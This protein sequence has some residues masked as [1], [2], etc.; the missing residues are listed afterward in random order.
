MAVAAAIGVGSDSGPNDDG[1]GMAR[2]GGGICPNPVIVPN[3]SSN[4]L[5][6]RLNGKMRQSQVHAAIPMGDINRSI[7]K[8]SI[9]GGGGGHCGSTVLN[10]SSTGVKG[11]NY[12]PKQQGNVIRRDSNWTNSTEG[13]GSMRSSDQSMLSRRCSD[14]SAMSHNSNFSTRAVRNSPWADPSMSAPSSRRSS[15]VTNGQAMEEHPQQQQHPQGIAQHLARLHQKADLAIQNPMPM[16]D[17]SGR[18]SAMSECSLPTSYHPH[19]NMQA[20]NN[21]GT[22]RRA[23]DPYGTSERQYAVVGGQLARHRSYTQLS[24]DQSQRAPLHG[25]PISGNSQFHHSAG[26][27]VRKSMTNKLSMRPTTVPSGSD[28]YFHTCCPSSLCPSFVLFVRPYFRQCV[29]KL[30]T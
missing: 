7:E 1:A 20:N 16:G 2:V 8:M 14:I 24:S 19:Q 4:A 5:T 15:I 25:Q 21:N 18:Q 28:N 27:Q 3:I 30:Q 9:G 6:N 17:A 22:I 26:N 11:S 10:P 23:S 12:N 29:L 13:Y